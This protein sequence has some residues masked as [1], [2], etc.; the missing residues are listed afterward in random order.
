MA[1]A[2]FV[3]Y[4]I[5]LSSGLAAAYPKEC[6]VGPDYWCKSLKN[7]QDCGAIRHCTDTVWSYDDKYALVDLSK[8]CQWCEK[9]LGNTHKGLGDNENLMI[10]QLTI[11][12]KLLPSDDFSLKC[13]YVIENYQTSVLSLMKNKRYATLCRLMNICSNEK[14]P[15]IVGNNRC[16]WGPA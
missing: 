1:K 13:L 11:G 16:T 14:A 5:A 9:I 15:I 8:T 4:L 3:T 10:S 7:A 2:L 6:A 12:C